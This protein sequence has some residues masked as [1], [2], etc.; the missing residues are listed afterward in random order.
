MIMDKRMILNGAGTYYFK[1]QGAK[2]AP[3]FRSVFEYEYFR[4]LLEQESGCELIAYVFSEYQAQW[5]MHCTQDWQV[6]LDNLRAHMQELYFKL[7][8]KHQQVISESA[9][10]I[11]IEEDKFLVPLV[12]ELHYWPVR[13]GLVAKPEV[14]PWSS[15][16]D[17][18]LAQ[19]HNN[20]NRGL[21]CER[22][23]KRLS[24]QRFNT[25]LRYER[26]MEQFEPLDINQA[27]NRLYQ[28]L[29]SDAYITLHLRGKPAKIPLSQEQVTSLRQQAE[30]HI[31]KILGAP[32]EQVRH[33]RFRR[34]YFQVEPLTIWLL[35]KT[36]CTLEQLIFIFDLDETIIQGWL[37]SI[38][39]QHPESFLTKLENTWKEDLHPSNTLPISQ[40][41]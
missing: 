28:A 3:L 16:K 9:D 1:V 18:R 5:V 25:T 39:T 21:N 36:N 33:P 41:S 23:L 8:H 6:V 11:F 4:K 7:W 38:P 32:I 15:D 31:C 30:E 40:A 10:V 19:P 22:M 13:E 29:A 34:Q 26:M 27:K 20:L 24:K 2:D 35:L 37:R 12:M 14:Y 17:Y